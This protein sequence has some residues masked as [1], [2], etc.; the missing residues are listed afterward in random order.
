MSIVHFGSVVKVSS[1]ITQLK[2]DFSTQ[3]S[4]MIH[5]LIAIC[6]SSEVRPLHYMVTIT[7]ATIKKTTQMDDKLLRILPLPQKKLLCNCV[8]MSKCNPS[9]SICNSYSVCV[10]V[11]QI[12]YLNILMRH[13]PKI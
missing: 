6:H 2:H 7:W 3:A 12:K 13:Q 10:I 8:F 1:N 9:V 11:P 5:G 4:L